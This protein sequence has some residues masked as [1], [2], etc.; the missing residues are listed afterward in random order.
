[1]GQFAV[2]IVLGVRKVALLLLLKFRVPASAIFD[3]AA[4]PGISQATLIGLGAVRI[5]FL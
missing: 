3:L 2:Y 4:V 1:M 5:G